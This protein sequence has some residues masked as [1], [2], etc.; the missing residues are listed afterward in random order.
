MDYQ[1]KL[2]EK[3]YKGE[4]SLEEEQELKKWLLENG[5]SEAESDI[6]GFYENEARIPGDLEE[7]LITEIWEHQ[8]RSKRVRKLR[9]YSISSAAAVVLVLI[10][11][12]IDFRNE[13]KAKMENDFFVMEQAL[14][15]V[16]HSLQPEEQQEMM[17]LW[18]GDNVEIIVN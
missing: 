11:I 17:V 8:K 12:Y 15:Q 10:S 13:R 16:S 2:L 9:L 18:V 6:F 3:Y 1:E 5:S 14:F 7:S 4:T